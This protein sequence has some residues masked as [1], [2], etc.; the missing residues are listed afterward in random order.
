[1]LWTISIGNPFEQ[2]TFGSDV[3]NYYCHNT[4][5]SCEVDLEDNI[6]LSKLKKTLNAISED[7][8][9]KISDSLKIIDP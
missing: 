9:I 4:V 2:E 7:D 5:H 8:L 6:Q 1:M 3:Q